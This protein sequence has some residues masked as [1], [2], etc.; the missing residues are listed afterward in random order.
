[1]LSAWFLVYYQNSK[2]KTNNSK[3]KVPPIIDSTSAKF[4]KNLSAGSME[5]CVSAYL[6]MNKKNL[7]NFDFARNPPARI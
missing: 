2:P 5:I 1:V 7:K 3:L 4:A 6:E